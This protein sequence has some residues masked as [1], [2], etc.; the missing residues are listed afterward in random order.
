MSDQLN[1]SQL[2]TLHGSQR[3]GRRSCTWRRGEEIFDPSLYGVALIESDRE[4]RAFVEL[5]HYSASYPAA[6]CRVGLYLSRGEWMAPLLVGVAVFSVPMNQRVIIKHCGVSPHEGVEL[7]RLV[8]LD[9]VPAP[10][11]S[12]FLA[13]AFKLL[14]ARLPAVRA[15][16]SYSDP[17]MR[18]TAAGETIMPG[19]IGVIYQAHNGVYRGRGS[20]RTLW[21]ARD[22]RVVPARSLSK[23]R[24]GERGVD[25]ACRQ[26][27]SMGAPARMT[28]E[29]GAA[30][31][32]RALESG[33][34]R[35]ARHPGNHVYVWG[36][37]KKTRRQMGAGDQYPKV[38]E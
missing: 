18:R 14:R 15:V 13:R 17:M 30:Y 34:F 20:K 25:Y 12:W 10:G 1:L 31:V 32:T 27:V 11:E 21:L 3:W 2:A 35:R 23:I 16:V 24:R 19:H 7:G 33:V 9:E 26:L 6:R 29:D 22:A 37:N 28:H 5:H 38:K 36:L 8:L 4:A